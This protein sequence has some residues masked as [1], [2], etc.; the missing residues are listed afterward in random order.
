MLVCPVGLDVVVLFT[1]CVP[2]LFVGEFVGI[3]VDWDCSFAIIGESL[4]LREEAIVYNDYH[5]V[6][7]LWYVM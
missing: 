4:W 6:E 5:C 7:G 1:D 2:R 3:V